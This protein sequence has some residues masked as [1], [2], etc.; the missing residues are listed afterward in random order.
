ML[1]KA[2]VFIVDVII[3][4]M[5][6]KRG[7]TVNSSYK[8]NFNTSRVSSRKKI[9]GRREGVAVLRTVSPPLIVDIN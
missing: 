6:L 8:F 1:K 4:G 9:W 7:S 5:S 3:S 2:L